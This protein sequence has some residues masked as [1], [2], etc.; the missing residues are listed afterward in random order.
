MSVPKKSEDKKQKIRAVA[1]DQNM[2]LLI[3]AGA[4][5]EGNISKFFRAAILNYFTNHNKKNESTSKSQA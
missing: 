2:D 3:T 4:K 5:I 1:V